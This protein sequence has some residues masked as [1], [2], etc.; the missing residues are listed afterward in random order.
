MM[1]TRLF[2]E[3]DSGRLT[4]G[5]LGALT[6]ALAHLGTGCGTQE[7][8]TSRLLLSAHLPTDLNTAALGITVVGD[9]DT[10]EEHQA[11]ALQGLDDRYSL[12]IDGRAAAWDD[13]Q[14]ITV[15]SGATD[16]FWAP[17][18]AHTFEL[19]NAS[20]QTVLQRAHDLTAGFAH[21]LIGYGDR[22]ALSSAFFSF[23]LDIP[24]GMQRFVAMNLVRDQT[25]EALDCSGSPPQTCTAL[26]PTLTYGQ[27]LQGEAILRGDLPLS[28]TGAASP[29]VFFRMTPTAAVPTPPLGTFYL[30]GSAYN[31]TLRDDPPRVT[32]PPVFLG[33]P[34]FLSSLGYIQQ[35]L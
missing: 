12:R 3:R 4:T 24:S 17:A 31:A 25:I 1:T 14:A 5:A 6:L 18:G 11:A 13:G 33:I 27:S 34:I 35:Q 10:S 7:V 9:Y 16:F 8:E 26:S 30:D 28:P 2:P 32:V 19:I 22:H 21:R 20:A 15:G 29:N 23:D